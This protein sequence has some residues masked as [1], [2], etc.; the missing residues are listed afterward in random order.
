MIACPS[1]KRS[2]LSRRDLLYASFDGAI[3]CPRCGRTASLAQISRWMILCVLSIVL[4]MLLLHGGVF[5]SGHLFAVS[6]VIV[7]GSWAILCW[8]CFPFLTLEASMTTRPVDRRHGVM[9]II[10]V[11]IA[12]I[13]LDGYIASRFANEEEEAI[14]R[15]PTSALRENR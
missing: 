9:T 15:R 7:F 11:L 6:I 1:C 3:V 14:D 12:A 10:A 5:Y 2:V 13:L 8:A 4:P